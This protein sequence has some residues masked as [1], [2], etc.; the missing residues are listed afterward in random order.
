MPERVGVMG[1]TFDPVH[2]GHLRVAEEAVEALDLDMLLFI[3][4]AVPPHKLGKSILAFEHRWRMLRLATDEHPRFAV[5]DLEQRLP[6]KSY[7]V[8][9]LRKLQ[10]EYGGKAELFFIVGMDA[11][12]ELNTWW[13][14]NELFELAHMVVLRRRGYD[15]S[16][17]NGF[18]AQRVSAHYTCTGDNACFMHPHLLPVHCLNN[19]R[20][21]ISSTRIRQLVKEGRSIRYLVVP[22]VMRYICSEQLYRGEDLCE[23]RKMPVCKKRGLP[24]G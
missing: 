14:F 12:F 3:P 1:G 22:E 11:F 16:E 5:S 6:G 8:V 9:T 19:T 15:E 23:T 2:V 17:V 7:T 20:L 10:E 24:A 21:D 18:L 13:H 4:A